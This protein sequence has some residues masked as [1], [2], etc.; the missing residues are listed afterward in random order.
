MP[1]PRRVVIDANVWISALLSPSGAPAR[2]LG[3]V[4]AGEVIAVVSPRLVEELGAVLARPKFRRWVSLSDA[5]EFT[6]AVAARA[7]L[8]PDVAQPPRTTRD[9]DDD[10]LVALCVSSGARLVS[11]DADVLDADLDPPALSP[12]ALLALL[13]ATS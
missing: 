5:Q 8:Y 7:D 12:R 9:R 11:G 13:D 1:G 2:V 3:A 10:Y 4:L 6:R